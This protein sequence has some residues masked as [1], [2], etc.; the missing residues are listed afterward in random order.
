MKRAVSLLPLAATSLALATAGGCIVA[1]SRETVRPPDA[2]AAVRRFTVSPQDA[3]KAIGPYSPGVVSG[4]T[5]WISGQI[6]LDPA[7]GALVDGGISAQAR[8]ALENVM[9][10]VRAAGFRPSD[11]V[12]VQV[13]LTDLS[14]F[15][16]VNAVYAEFFPVDP[17]ARATLQVSALP[18]GAEVEIA[19]V[20]RKTK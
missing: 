2:S 17:P 10:V 8:R 4:D 16:A 3:P 13:F 18:R 20:A 6:G 5:L 15:D 12:Q 1:S 19:A 7:S 9:A 11:I 14:R